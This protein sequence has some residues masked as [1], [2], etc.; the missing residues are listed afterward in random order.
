MCYHLRDK[1]DYCLGFSPTEDCNETLAKFIPKSMVYSDY[2]EEVLINMM[3][4]QKK[5]WRV[6][7][8]QGYRVLVILDDCCYDKK[9]LRSKVIREIFMNGR[10]RHV[11]LIISAQ[12]VMD[13][14]PDLRTQVDYVFA[15]R[16]NVIKNRERLWKQ[17]F[18]FFDSFKHFAKVMDDCTQ[19]YECLVCDNKTS[20][21]NS[22][23]SCVFWYKALYDIPDYRLGHK[24]VWKLHD[25]YYKEENFSVPKLPKLKTLQP[26][27]KAIG[28]REVLHTIIKQ[29]EHGRNVD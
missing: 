27:K 18:G 19:N 11:T 23:E 13:M 5:L 6:P 9:I 25:F 21:D 7:N 10:H 15:L 20:K 2:H 12:Y 26:K 28:P 3:D 4:I 8:K 17:F 16:E 22:I 14:P 24:F 29:D 1:I